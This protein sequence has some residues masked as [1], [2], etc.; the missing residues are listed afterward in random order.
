MSSAFPILAG[1]GVI[2]HLAAA[3]A[4]SYLN[5][6]Y[7]IGGALLTMMPVIVLLGELLALC[8]FA[9]GL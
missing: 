7:R 1:F 2:G 5:D 4:F 3:L 6:V 8:Y 9:C